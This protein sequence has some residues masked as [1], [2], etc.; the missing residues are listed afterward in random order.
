[1]DNT[2][3]GLQHH[4]SAFF[5]FACVQRAEKENRKNGNKLQK[6]RAMACGWL[7]A[8]TAA[9]WLCCHVFLLMTVSSLPGQ[10][11]PRWF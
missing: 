6:Q 2:R 5:V 10:D 4:H 9:Y 7:P 1:M 3:S 11:I 8:Q